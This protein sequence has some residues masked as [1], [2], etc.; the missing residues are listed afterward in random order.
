MESDGIECRSDDF[1]QYWSW[2]W[3]LHESVSLF[4][5]HLDESATARTACQIIEIDQLDEWNK[6][7]KNVN[8]MIF[9]TIIRFEQLKLQYHVSASKSLRFLF[10][11]K[12]L[13]AYRW[14]FFA[15]FV[16][17]AKQTAIA[18][19]TNQ[20]LLGT[21][22]NAVRWRVIEIV[23]NCTSS[24]GIHCCRNNSKTSDWYEII[25]WLFL[26][27]PSLLENSEGN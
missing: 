24:G 7:Q 20:I 21:L 18:I 11:V 14:M 25:L 15:H 17:T 4:R 9:K 16:N 27:C 1:R 26:E 10:V 6:T 13:A 19:Q 22:A 12:K 2:M 8:Q 3:C 23:C 5:D